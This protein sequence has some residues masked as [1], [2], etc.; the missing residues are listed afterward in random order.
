MKQLITA[1]LFFVLVNLNAQELP[2]Y[3]FNIESVFTSPYT[4]GDSDE[5]Y[6]KFRALAISEE[7][8][9]YV[10]LEQFSLKGMEGR[11]KALVAD[12]FL[13][14]RDFN[15][16]KIDHVEFIKWKSKFILQVKINWTEGYEIDISE[17]SD[18]KISVKKLE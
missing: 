10:T 16:I 5:N 13:L 14:S 7:G 11:E 8:H 17:Y 1:V 4:I 15:K 12:Y 9:F 18:N 3:Y 6:S 2:S